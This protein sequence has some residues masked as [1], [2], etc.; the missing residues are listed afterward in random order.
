MCKCDGD[1]GTACEDGRRSQRK[2]KLDKLSRIV[3]DASKRRFYGKVIVTFR[4][5][6]PQNIEV[7]ETHKL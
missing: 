2:E 5:G 1:A 7:A 4:D 3:H 6:T